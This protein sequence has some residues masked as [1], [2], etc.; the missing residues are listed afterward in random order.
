VVA[1]GQLRVEDQNGNGLREVDTDPAP[2][3]GVTFSA[4][5]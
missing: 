3:V 4:R 2:L 5:Y 1:A